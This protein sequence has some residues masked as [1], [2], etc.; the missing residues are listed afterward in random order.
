M[1]GMQSV[2]MRFIWN[3]DITF[4][5][6]VNRDEL[7]N[8]MAM[9]KFSKQVQVDSYVRDNPQRGVKNNNFVEARW[10]SYTMATYESIKCVDSYFEVILSQKYNF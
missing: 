2:N 8:N 10:S 9:G 4:N 1:P 3:A 6:P 5:T 7:S